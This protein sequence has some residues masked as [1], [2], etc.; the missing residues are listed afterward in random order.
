MAKFDAVMRQWGSLQS[1]KINDIPS[2][3]LG[4]RILNSLSKNAPKV[5][6]VFLENRSILLGNHSNAIFIDTFF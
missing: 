6:Q 4:Q 5:A 2:L 1:D 3:P